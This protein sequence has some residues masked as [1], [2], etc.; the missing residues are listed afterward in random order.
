ML[1]AAADGADFEEAWWIVALWRGDPEAFEQLYRQ[2][3]DA[4]YG[5][6]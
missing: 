1:L 3:V 5:L 4:L 6:A 2:H